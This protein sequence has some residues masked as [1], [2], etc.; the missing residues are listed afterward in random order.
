MEED[1]RNRPPALQYEDDENEFQP[2]QR[3]RSSDV[4]WMIM[5]DGF[6]EMSSSSIIMMDELLKKRKENRKKMN[7]WKLISVCEILM[8]NVMII[9]QL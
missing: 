7:Y 5:N 1:D 9:I 4:Y 6:M 3:M 8:Y 2:A